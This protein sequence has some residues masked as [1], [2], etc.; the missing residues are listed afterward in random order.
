MEIK[1]KVHYVGVNDR[2]KALF[3]NLLPLPYGV[4]YN[5]CLLY[6]SPKFS[7]KDGK[8]HSFLRYTSAHRKLIKEIELVIID[9]ISMVR[10]DIID[11]VSYTHLLVRYRSL[12]SI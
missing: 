11:S 3:E 8:L 2:N 7:L 12:G 6:T 10:A 1:G 9:E 4:S 5:S